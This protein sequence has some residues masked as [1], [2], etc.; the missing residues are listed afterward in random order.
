MRSGVT[1]DNIEVISYWREE[2]FTRQKRTG[3]IHVLHFCAIIQHLYNTELQE[4]CCAIVIHYVM[5]GFPIILL[6]NEIM[7]GLS[8][9]A[10]ANGPAQQVANSV[11]C[12]WT[13]MLR[14]FA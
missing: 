7:F 4:L 10:H 12:C 11:A 14:S 13:T 5:F 8:L 6:H 9:K 2:R 1:R 3:R